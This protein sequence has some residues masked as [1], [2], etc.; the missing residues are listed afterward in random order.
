YVDAAREE[1]LL[2][3]AKHFP[4]H[5]GTSD[6]S[7]ATLPVVNDNRGTLDRTDLYPFRACIA[8]GVVLV[9]TAHVAF[10]A[11]DPELRPA[12]LS[13]PILK[14]LLR[15]QL[16]F[17]GVVISDSMMMAG[18]R[19]RDGSPDAKLLMAGVD[20]LLDPVDPVQAVEAI[21]AAVHAG[22][23]DPSALDAAVARVNALKSRLLKR[24]G[25]RVFAAPDEV[26][27][28]VIPGAAAHQEVA[29]RIASSALTCSDPG[30]PLLGRLIDRA[31]SATVGIFPSPRSL[32][33]AG[34]LVEA[35]RVLAPHANVVV[36]EPDANVAGSIAAMQEP[37]VF[38][39]A[40]MIRPAAWH[41]YGLTST[42]EDALR[43]ASSRWPT[44]LGVLG[45]EDL[46][47]RLPRASVTVCTH[48]D[49]PPSLEALAAFLFGR[50]DR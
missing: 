7:H 16:G 37:D 42:Q 1:G 48:S 21:V 30:H 10:P 35:V 12:T 38:V 8:A 17:E 39:A 50:R 43:Q 5:G 18:V 33:L 11:F 15:G 41:A 4:G 46:V 34:T 40:V 13:P 25:S 36:V 9:M 19:Q 26:F 14:D 2:T 29:R 24:H 23:V 20:V 44:V 6:D 27:A 22:A 3:T 49:M 45:S 47:D 28:D 32:P 31:T